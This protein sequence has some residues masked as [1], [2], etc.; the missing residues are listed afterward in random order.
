MT[1]VVNGCSDD[2]TTP[3]TRSITGCASGSGG[4][5]RVTTSGSHDYGPCD[6]VT[7]SGVTGTTEANGN[8]EITIV[9]STHFELDGSTFANAY[10]SGGSVVD[11]SLTPQLQ[12]PSNGEAGVV[13]ALVSAVD[14]LAS[15]TQ[16]LKHYIDTNI[17]PKNLIAAAAQNVGTAGS[18]VATANSTT[19]VDINTISGIAVQSGDVLIVRAE[20]PATA[21]GASTPQFTLTAN[22]G[23][24]HDLTS[25]QLA[26][27]AAWNAWVP[28]SGQFTATTNGTISLRS[29]FRNNTGTQIISVDGQTTLSYLQYRASSPT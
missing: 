25:S 24:D 22:D 11:H 28:I 2:V 17:S 12:M 23:S 27:S 14:A 21:T 20:C 9:D 19:Y 6:H 13:D 29:R 5:I 7:V 26:I 10:A 18:L 8:W 3:L 1:Q 15:R 4:V 16:Y